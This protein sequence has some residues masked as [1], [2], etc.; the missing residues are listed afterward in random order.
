MIKVGI[1]RRFGK[2]QV[3]AAVKE[4]AEG[5]VEFQPGEGGAHAKVDT[6][7]E[8]RVGRALAVIMIPLL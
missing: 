8:R 3:G 6:G 2:A 5:H 4:R 7:A 1:A